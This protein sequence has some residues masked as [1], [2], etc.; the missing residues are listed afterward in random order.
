M[1]RGGVRVEGLNRV[2]RALQGLGLDVEDL[3]GAFGAIADQAVD[4]IQAHVP[5]RSGAL[6][7]DIRGNKSKNKAVVRAG[8]A[9]IPYAGPINYGWP[10]RGIEAAGFMQKGD[11]EMQ[12]I[13]AQLLAD[14]IDKR[15]RARGL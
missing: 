8:R 2:T 10:K 6:A 11:E 4:R 1:P 9:A 15:V 5:K 7:S 14:E 3:V 12:P 13:A